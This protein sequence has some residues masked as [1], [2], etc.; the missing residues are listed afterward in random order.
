MGVTLK[1][2][3]IVQQVPL[4][5]VRRKGPSTIASTYHRKIALFGHLDGQGKSGWFLL[6]ILPRSAIISEVGNQ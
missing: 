3:A 4:G 5:K 1:V 2:P 6:M